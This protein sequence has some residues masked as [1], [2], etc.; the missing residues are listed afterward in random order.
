V[1]IS[2]HKIGKTLRNQPFSVLENITIMV[3]H[4][5]GLLNPLTFLFFD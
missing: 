1:N 4:T 3:A 5:A 2:P